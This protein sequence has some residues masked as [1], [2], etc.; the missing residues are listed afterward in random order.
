MRNEFQYLGFGLII[1]LYS[2]MGG[3]G[4]IIPWEIQLIFGLSIMSYGTY[5]LLQNEERKKALKYVLP[6]WGIFALVGVLNLSSSSYK[7]TILDS[8]IES[9]PN[10]DGIQTCDEGREKARIDVENGELRYMFGGFGSRK[11]L[12][13]NLK[14]YGVEVI[15]LNGLVGMPNECYNQIMY[16]EIQKRFG[17]DIFNRENK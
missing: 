11:P 13:E 4:L 5:L 15:K 9:S 14:K 10:F 1:S 6:V 7:N 2:L 8:D 3:G 12:A 17:A 16:K